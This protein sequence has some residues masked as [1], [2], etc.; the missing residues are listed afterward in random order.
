MLTPETTETI[1]TVA[2]GVVLLITMVMGHREIKRR[3]RP[4]L[5]IAG[6]ED[7]LED[8]DRRAGVRRSELQ[9][10]IRRV[11]ELAKKLD[12]LVDLVADHENRLVE[13]DG[14]RADMLAAIRELTASVNNMSQQIAR[15]QA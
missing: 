5:S 2:E 12:E 7:G 6:D 4:P 10:L 1:R 13:A 9:T 11:T 15:G 8:A 14:Y 3:R